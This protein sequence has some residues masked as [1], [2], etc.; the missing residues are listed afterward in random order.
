MYE[1]TNDTLRFCPPLP[2][3]HDCECL[4][5]SPVHSTCWPQ[6]HRTTTKRWPSTSFTSDTIYPEQH[7]LLVEF[8]FDNTIWWKL[9]LTITARSWQYYDHR[10]NEMLEIVLDDTCVARKLILGDIKPRFYGASCHP[11]PVRVLA[12]LTPQ[13]F[14]S[15]FTQIQPNGLNSRERRQSARQTNTRTLRLRQ[16]IS[17]LLILRNDDDD[18]DESVSWPE[19]YVDS[20]RGVWQMPFPVAWSRWCWGHDIARNKADDCYRPEHSHRAVYDPSFHFAYWTIGP[21]TGRNYSGERVLLGS[22][23]APIAWRERK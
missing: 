2:L 11:A 4:L 1:D 7:N 20:F 12:K 3:A 10:Y 15:G 5:H 17:L 6:L 14:P 8:N 21:N 19:T 13:L 23:T 16:T 22:S 9:T 18:D